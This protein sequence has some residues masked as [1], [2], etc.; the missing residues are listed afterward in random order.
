MPASSTTWRP[1]LAASVPSSGLPNW[2]QDHVTGRCLRLQRQKA[3]AV[4]AVASAVGGAGAG[5]RSCGL[6]V[7]G[8]QGGLGNLMFKYASLWGLAATNR[9]EPILVSPRKFPLVDIFHLTIPMPDKEPKRK[10]Q[11]IGPAPFHSLF[12]F[13]SSCFLATGDQGCC[14]FAS[15]LVEMECGKDYQMGGYLQSFKYF[16]VLNSPGT[17]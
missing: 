7:T 14:K 15:R 4:A 16:E 5:N 11:K 2:R 8:W 6:L 1:R 17:R 10:Y 3:A 13:V 12:G 9:R